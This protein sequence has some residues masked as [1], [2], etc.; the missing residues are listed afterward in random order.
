MTDVYRITA[1]ITAPIYETEVPDRVVR[2]V[3][4]IFPTADVET[5]DVEVRATS[6]S[7]EHL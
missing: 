2:A 1:E 4:A 7:L 6:H 3:E 5:T